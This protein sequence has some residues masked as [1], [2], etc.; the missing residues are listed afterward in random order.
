V[1]ELARAAVRYAELGWYV[2]PLVPRRKVPLTSHG[3]LDASCDHGLVA[4]WWRENP[5]ANIG[6]ACSPSGL[7]VVDVDGEEAAQAWA[8]L[9]ARHHGHAKT[10]TARTASGWHHYF[11]GEGRSTTG[12]LAPGID[13]RGR[14][15]YVVVPP[16]VH[17]SGTVYRWLKLEGVPLAPLPGWVAEALEPPPAAPVGE[18]RM[19]PIGSP[20]TR[21]GLAALAGLVDE[22][23]G[24]PEGQRNAT[25]N[26]LAYRA[27]R[28]V[29]AGELAEAVAFQALVD[30]ALTSGLEA[31]EAGRTFRSGFEAGLQRPLSVEARR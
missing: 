14:G 28:L 1:N 30:A 4:A 27:G 17:E 12:R 19:L 3:L 8:D 22:M 18:P 10:F 21:Y 24:T 13:T 15:G 6:V 20:Y 7:L 11:A 5:R 16:S 29:A 31:D 9:C 23:A 2:F 26:A 25:L